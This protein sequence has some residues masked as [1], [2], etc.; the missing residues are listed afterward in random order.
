VT[1]IENSG[2][3]LLDLINDIL[4]LSKIEAKK[5]ELFERTFSISEM[6]NTSLERV[7]PMADAKNISIESIAPP[8]LPFLKADERRVIQVF[9][10]LLNN[11]IKFTPEGGQITIEAEIKKDNSCQII[12]TDTGI[13]IA[14]SDLSRIIKPFEQSGNV[15]TTPQ[16]GT[17]LGLAICKSLIEMHEG[18]FEITSKTGEG[19]TVT[20]TFPKERVSEVN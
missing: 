17:G 7:F 20:V 18:I 10:N 12:V 14:E 1:D 19:T 2:N 6:I 16:E 15:L 9:I 8:S 5:E 4:D 3:H 13:G 11:S